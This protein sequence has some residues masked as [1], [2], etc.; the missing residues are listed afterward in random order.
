M[1]V[2]LERWSN[3]QLVVTGYN[4]KPDTYYQWELYDENDGSIE[5]NQL[6][7]NGGG[8]FQHELGDPTSYPQFVS[9]LTFVL[10]NI[11]GHKADMR[12]AIASASLEVEV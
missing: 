9:P 12:R 3:G 6:L 5:G 11:K 1:N 8:G 2:I 10:Y 4:F 7:T